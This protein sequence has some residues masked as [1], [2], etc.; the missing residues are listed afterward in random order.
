MRTL[1]LDRNTWTLTERKAILDYCE[2]DVDGLV[3]LLE[4]M[5]T[6][7]DCPRALLR[8]KVY[9]RRCSHGA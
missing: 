6:S 3:V 2:S 8:W 4:A 1:I 7:I 5:A 9:V